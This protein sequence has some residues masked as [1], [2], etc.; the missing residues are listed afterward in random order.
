MMYGLSPGFGDYRIW[1][2]EKAVVELRY[3]FSI[4]VWDKLNCPN[5]FPVQTRTQWT[6][7]DDPA[8]TSVLYEPS[9]KKSVIATVLTPRVLAQLE[10][11][12][13]GIEFS[14]FAMISRYSFNGSGCEIMLIMVR[15][16]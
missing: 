12:R 13:A 1:T 8:V 2:S 15:R 5:R 4:I 7:F 3:V 6:N 16:F 14:S 10:N 11:Y 9:D